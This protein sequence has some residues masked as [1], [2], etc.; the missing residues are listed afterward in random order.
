MVWSLKFDCWA[1]RAKGVP[2]ARV[3][4]KVFL[5]FWA[6]SAGHHHAAF[7]SMQGAKVGDRQVFEMTVAGRVRV[8]TLPLECYGPWRN[9]ARLSADRLDSCVQRR[10]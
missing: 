9:K 7:R 3:S 2:Q 5:G 6:S 4:G 10:C 1:L 8:L